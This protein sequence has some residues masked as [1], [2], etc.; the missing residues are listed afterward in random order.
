MGV[1]AEA[2]QGIVVIEFTETFSMTAICISE[3][4]SYHN[5]A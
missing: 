1:E 4:F 5:K 3:S 2:K